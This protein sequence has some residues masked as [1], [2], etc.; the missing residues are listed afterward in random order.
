[1]TPMDLI[2]KKI[3]VMGLGLLG[4]GVG[5][6]A[7]LASKGAELIVTDMKTKEQLATSLEQLKAFPHIKY[8]LGKHEFSDFENRDLILKAAGVPLDSSYIAHAR[9]KGIP[10]RMSTALFAKNTPATI[11]G[12]TGTR[13][14]STT[15]CL[16]HHIL[17]QAFAGSDKKVFLGGNVRG[18]ST[19]PFLD[20][21]KGGDIA[22]L[23]LDSW[24]LQG[25]DEEKLSPHIS[26]FTTFQP[27]HLNYYKNDLDLYL[28][29]KSYIYKYQKP[30]DI[31][32]VG[33][34]IEDRVK[35]ASGKVI[36]AKRENVPSDWNI[37][38]PGEHNRL[39]IACAIAATRAMSIDEEV[40]KKAVESF[41]GVEGRLQKIKEVNGVEIW[42]DNNATTP[43]AT[44]AAIKALAPKPLVLIMGGAEKNINMS[45]LVNLVKGATKKIILLPG[46][47][48][49]NL[50]K[51]CEL[52]GRDIEKVQSMK[53]AVEI[54]V[55]SATEG[56]VI[57]FSPA[58]ASFGLFKNEYDRNDQ[59]VALVKAL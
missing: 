55:V 2:G 53:E 5:D 58:Y 25:F 28:Q 37:Q 48:T 56:D 44:I 23:E 22:V 33:E 12:I 24:Q 41:T 36:V 4:R 20:E 42:N 31:L 34:D 21:A 30:D 51:N 43:D 16:I 8:I 47:G 54:A 50:L 18:V 40:I 38:I 26:V 6:V 9:D 3:T 7:Y 11:I 27:D 59:F 15:T 57:L 46:T 52:V 19:L 45:S 35:D 29:D 13:G 49:D 1:M 10:I 14:K 39:N 17:E 32:V